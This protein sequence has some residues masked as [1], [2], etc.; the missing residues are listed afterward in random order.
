MRPFSSCVGGAYARSRA[1]TAFV[2]LCSDAAWQAFASGLLNP[3]NSILMCGRVGHICLWTPIPPGGAP[4]AHRWDKFNEFV[5]LLMGQQLS[6]LCT[7]RST[8]GASLPI[9][10]GPLIIKPTRTV[11]TTK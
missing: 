4:Q 1:R 11:A 5:I 3:R 7:S 2:L 6:D 9:G 8:F 10:L